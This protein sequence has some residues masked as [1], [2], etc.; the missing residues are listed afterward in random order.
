M[1]YFFRLTL[2]QEPPA[3]PFLYRGE[4]DGTHEI[5]LVLDEEAGSIYPSDSNGD[6]IASIH[7]DIGDGNISGTTDDPNMTKGFPLMAAH[8][9]MQ[10]KKQGNPPQEIRKFFA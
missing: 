8:L 7:M 9:L 10:W 1:T 5:F 4:V 6:R 3:P 2:I